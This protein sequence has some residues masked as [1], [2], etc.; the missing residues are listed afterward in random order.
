MH[1]LFLLQEI[2]LLSLSGSYESAASPGVL[3]P[4][5][6]AARWQAHGDSQA[7]PRCV[8]C[9][10]TRVS[11]RASP[12]RRQKF[13]NGCRDCRDAWDSSRFQTTSDKKGE[14]MKQRE[15]AF[16]PKFSSQHRCNISQDKDS[17]VLTGHAASERGEDLEAVG[18]A[19]SGYQALS[20]VWS[21]T[22]LRIQYICCIWKCIIA[23]WFHFLEKYKKSVHHVTRLIMF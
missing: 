18:H 17:S 9:A 2:D 3:L 8:H 11:M 22:V 16:L 13:V 12:A 19:A 6:G 21:N 20:R 7:Q 5:T 4:F 23:V 10:H 1:S 15:R 14:R